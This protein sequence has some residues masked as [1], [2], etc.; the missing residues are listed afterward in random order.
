LAVRARSGHPDVVDASVALCATEREHAIVTADPG[1]LTR[2]NPNLELVTIPGPN[3][4]HAQPH[5][6]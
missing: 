4:H 2:V 5:S 6:S 1:D 3:R